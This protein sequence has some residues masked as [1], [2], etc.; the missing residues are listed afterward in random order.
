MTIRYNNLILEG[1]IMMH[2]AQFVL[3]RNDKDGGQNVFVNVAEVERR[4]AAP[5]RMTSTTSIR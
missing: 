2:L 3:H 5:Y 1:L 4:S